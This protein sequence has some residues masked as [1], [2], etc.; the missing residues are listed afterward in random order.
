MVQCVNIFHTELNH[1]YSL[2]SE[3]HIMVFI[4]A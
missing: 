3:L 4:T 1:Y 2:Q